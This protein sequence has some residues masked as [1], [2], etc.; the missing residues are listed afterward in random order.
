MAKQ[1]LTAAQLVQHLETSEYKMRLSIFDIATLKGVVDQA[2]QEL[3]PS[4][5]TVVGANEASE[6]MIQGFW[7][8]LYLLS[9]RLQEALNSFEPFDAS[10]LNES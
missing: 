9:G 2:I 6:A 10:A 7:D 3:G 5:D 1:I 4:A 8:H